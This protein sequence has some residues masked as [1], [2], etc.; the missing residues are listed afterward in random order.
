M[1]GSTAALY[2]MRGAL[3][4]HPLENLPQ[5]IPDMKVKP[6]RM[7]LKRS[8]Q[9]RGVVAQNLRSLMKA[10]PELGTQAALRKASGVGGGSLEGAIK[11]T[12]NTGID[13]LE[14]LARAFG[15]H[16]WQLLVPN[17]DPDNL[18][19]L[20]SADNERAFYRD[21]EQAIQAAV[22][23]TAADYKTGKQPK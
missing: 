3:S 22:A 2:P 19:L 23:E 21:L 6:T 9:L 4:P 18:P 12:R 10:A 13:T 16:G 15:L 14:M 1:I 20:R 11:G 17:L 7:P 5:R 8:E